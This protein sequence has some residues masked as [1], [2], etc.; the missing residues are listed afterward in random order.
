MNAL[1]NINI[2]RKFPLIFLVFFAGS[3]VS[4][5]IELQCEYALFFGEYICYLID[6]EVLNPSA[7][8]TI[9]GQH[10]GDR[11]NDDVDMVD[12][13]SSNTPF[14][15]PQ[16]FTTFPNIMDLAIENSNLQSINIPENVQLVWIFLFENNISRIDAGT[17]TGL[18]NQRR[19]NFL[20]LPSNLIQDVDEDAFVG[21]GNLSALVLLD[22]Q[23]TQ[24]KNR[25]LAPLIN[26]V[27]IDYE[28]NLLTIIEEDTFAWNS[29][30]QS[31]GLHNNQIIAI[32]P[33]FLASQRESSLS[34][35][36]LDNNNCINETFS[37]ESEDGWIFLNNELRDC[38][39][40]FIGEVS[41]VRR[42]IMEF[43]GNITIIDEFGNIIAR[44]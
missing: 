21:L 32:S 20:Y 6:I 15:I 23:I 35:I 12:I 43:V 16:I 27:R 1:T 5:D 30:I 13:I 7:N 11:T 31:I 2:S 8:V 37:V 41:E 34:I 22:N 29:N 38:F 19:L 42:V 44:F 9:T 18:A 26:A 28:L 24:I 33:K 25:T 3:N 10:I 40:N 39:H 17:V 14:M 36:S 4:Q